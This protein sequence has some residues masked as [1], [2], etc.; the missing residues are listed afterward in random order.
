[1]NLL[2]TLDT[3]YI[4]QLA[5]LLVSLQEANPGESFRI[6]V[7]HSSLTEADFDVLRGVADPARCV[8]ESYPV[9]DDM[10]SSAPIVYRYPREMYYRLFAARFLPADMD[11][12]L[13]L[14]PDIVVINPLRE[15]YNM[16]F[17][18]SLFA[19]ASHVHQQFQKFNALRLKT[20]DDSAYVNSGVLLM[21]LARL[22]QEQSVDE[23]LQYID[24]HRRTL[25][26]PDQDVL[27][28]VYAARIRPIEPLYYNLDEKYY[29]LYNLNPRNRQ[30]RIDLDWVRRHTAI[31]H[32]CG[33]NKPWV[34]GY[35]GE[36]D[37]FYREYESRLSA[38][39]LDS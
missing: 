26:L 11:R 14:D 34:K 25:L 33:K 13:Y 3:H 32:Y 27:N 35:H 38:A 15:L 7:A 10:L 5:V 24:E 17:D 29:N 39:A 18:G 19:A 1:M 2:F 31:I 9:R 21:N 8:I 37:V 6:C 23:V 30:N 28:A 4:H 20:P 12:I 16:P 22:R 36:F